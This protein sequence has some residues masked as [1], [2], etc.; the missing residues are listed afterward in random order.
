MSKLAEHGVGSMCYYP[1]PL[2]AQEAF[3]CYGYKNG[4]FPITERLAKRVI[5]L[6]MYPELSAES[7]TTIASVL[8]KIGQEMICSVVITSELYSTARL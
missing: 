3:A 5:S 4:D 7:I 8:E 1:I 2:H 6:P